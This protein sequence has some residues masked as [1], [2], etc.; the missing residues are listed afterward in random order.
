MAYIIKMDMK[1]KSDLRHEDMTIS[2]LKSLWSVL[3]GRI[4][5]VF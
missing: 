4:N 2:Y 3:T 5:T 1:N